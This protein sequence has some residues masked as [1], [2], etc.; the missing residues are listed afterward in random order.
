MVADPCFV[1]TSAWYAFSVPAETAHQ[2]LSEFLLADRYRLVTSDLV[3]VE[4]LNLLRARGQ[5]ERAA[6]LW[7]K[8]HDA[9]LVDLLELTATRLEEAWRVFQ[10]FRDKE[11]SFT[12]CTSYCLMRERRIKVACSLDQHFRQF[13][14]GLVFP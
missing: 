9:E 6:L 2:V 7:S 5:S 11:W 8:L 1:D 10:T 3:L 4:T 12:D 13:G 14:T